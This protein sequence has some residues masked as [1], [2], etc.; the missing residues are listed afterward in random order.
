MNWYL[1]KVIFR[2]GIGP[3]ENASQF[4]EHLRL[5]QADNFE[6]AFV[7]ARMIG[8][9]EE[10]NFINNQEQLVKWEFVNVAELIPLKELSDGLEVY[11]QI[12]ETEEARSYIHAV[13]Q[14]A[15]TLQMNHSPAF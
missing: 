13:H 10:D 6:E 15:A 1:A 8:I 9:T 2:I 5:I 4:D 14:K 12:H 11:S 7:K 3:E